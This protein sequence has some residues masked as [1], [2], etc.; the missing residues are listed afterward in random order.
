[1]RP[2]QVFH[3]CR[4]TV[5][6]RVAH[7]ERAGLQ[8]EVVGLGVRGGQ[9]CEPRTFNGVELEVQR[10]NDR[11]GG[12]TLKLGQLRGLTVV[13]MR[14]GRPAGR[15][16][17]QLEVQTHIISS[18]L[19]AAAED[20]VRLQFLHDLAP[21]LALHIL[22]NLK[23]RLLDALVRGR[24]EDGRDGDGA[25]SRELRGYCVGQSEREVLVTLIL[26]SI[27]EWQHGDDA[28]PSLRRSAVTTHQP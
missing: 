7:L 3:R 1:M 13:A 23:P 20:C 21:R 19:H 28:R 22:G 2:L 14:P 5:E 24:R 16:L 12:S 10:R 27:F 9:T 18:A 25:Q 8:V 15:A 26:A 17:E 4:N 6:E 11:L